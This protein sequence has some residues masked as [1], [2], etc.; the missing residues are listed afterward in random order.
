M[1][2]TGLCTFATF[3]NGYFNFTKTSLEN[4]PASVRSDI[5]YNT[6]QPYL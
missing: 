5:K 4:N 1:G 6:V 3:H 2:T